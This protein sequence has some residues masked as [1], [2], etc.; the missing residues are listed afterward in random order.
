MIM[1]ARGYS[2]VR[3][4]AGRG[5]GFSWNLRTHLRRCPRLSLRVIFWE[6]GFQ[7]YLRVT[8]AKEEASWN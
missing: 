3:D 6:T 2:W 1:S 4:T 8:S 5:G 7:L